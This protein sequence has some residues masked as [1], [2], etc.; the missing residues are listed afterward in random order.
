[1]NN[2]G[3]DLKIL[4]IYL[5]S[6]LCLKVQLDSQSV[7]RLRNF[8][9]Q[10]RITILVFQYRMTII[11]TKRYCSQTLETSQQNFI[12]VYSFNISLYRLILISIYFMIIRFILTM[13]RNTKEV[14]AEV[15]YLWRNDKML[16]F[17]KKSKK[18]NFSC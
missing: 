2:R 6:T 3:I 18:I 9:F 1:M 11:A 8:V 12:L 16:Q 7:S 10:R 5:H 14:F 4:S 15:L 17:K 13:T